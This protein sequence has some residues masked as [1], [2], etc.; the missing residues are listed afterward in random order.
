VFGFFGGEDFGLFHLAV[1]VSFL[2]GGEGGIAV[3]SRVGEV[4]GGGAG[5][6]EDVEPDRMGLVLPACRLE[7]GRDE[8]PAGIGFGGHS[9]AQWRFPLSLNVCC[10]PV[11][12]SSFSAVGGPVLW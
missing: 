7:L 9:Q 8:L 6:V 3:E 11:N 12:I 10:G 1:V 4:A 5:V 2:L